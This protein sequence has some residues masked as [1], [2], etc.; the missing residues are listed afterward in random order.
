MDLL[1]V[2]INSAISKHSSYKVGGEVKR[3]RNTKSKKRGM[4]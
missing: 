3:D 1:N 2:Y 4:T